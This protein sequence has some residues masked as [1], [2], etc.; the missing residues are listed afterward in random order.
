LPLDANLSESIYEL[1]TEQIPG[2]GACFVRVLVSDGWHTQEAIGG[3]FVI[4][5][6]PPEVAI[7][8]PLDGTGAREEQALV[9][10]GSAY[11]PEDGSLPDEALSWESDRDGLL[12]HGETLVLSGLTLSPGWHT[13]TL[14]AADSDSQIGS[15]SI[16]LFIGHRVYLP[17]ILKSYP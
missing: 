6:K 11:D 5:R 9:F 4:Q 3:P 16:N 10:S 8:A 15:A 7:G 13:I 14:H 1:D 17:V 12:G 2:G